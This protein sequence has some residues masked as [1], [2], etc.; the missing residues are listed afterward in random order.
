MQITLS[1]DWSKLFFDPLIKTK[2]LDYF[3]NE[4]MIIVVYGYPYYCNEKKW[5][6][7]NELSTKIL[8]EKNLFIHD[9]DGVFSIIYINKKRK[10]C[11]V[12]TDRY[13]IY[14]LYYMLNQEQI[15]LS[16]EIEA[17]IP[18]ISHFDINKK[19]VIEYLNFGYVLGDKTLI[20]G[21]RKFSGSSI[22]LI[23]KKLEI[24]REK[25]WDI[26]DIQKKEMMSKDEFRSEFNRHINKAFEL[27]QKIVLPL[28]GG[29]DSRLILSACLKSKEKLHCYTQGP[30]YHSDVKLAKTIAKYY[31][32]EH[33]H[34]MTGEENGK[35]L[36][37]K[38]KGKAGI[39]YGHLPFIEYLHVYELLE[40]EAGKGDLLLTGILGN[41]LYRHHPF[42]NNLPISNNKTDI[43][44]FIVYQTP[45]AFF[46][47]IRLIDFYNNLFT[48][49]N[50][51]SIEKGL[52][53]SVFEVLNKAEL[54]K[55]KLDFTRYYLFNIYCSNIAANSL[56]LTGRYFKIFGAFF[57]KT[58]LKQLKFADFKDMINAKL[59]EYIIG[60]NSKYLADLTYYN[61]GRIIKYL[62][63]FGN[64]ISTKIIHMQLFKHPDIANYHY[65]LK[66]N[67]S[68][69]LN[70]L[71]NYESMLSS[72][73]FNQVE[74]ERI[75]SI[76][77]GNRTCLINKKKLFLNF[78][79]DKFM[80]NLI[81]FELW[82]QE[83]SQGTPIR[84]L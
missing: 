3:E 41:Q 37:L 4:S 19:S 24:I 78:S 33:L 81:S 82:L 9:I 40:E 72:P 55:S 2:D 34:Y 15:T 54:A 56:K 51:D 50:A 43:A 44:R 77:I 49:Q 12:Y 83:T 73:L 67:N 58:L 70:E 26:L 64:K 38:V 6:L 68:Q 7:A 62:K 23:T 71:L 14:M 39:L 79:I 36:K 25:Y 31:G 35:D 20:H 75:I 76:Y 63:L 11:K 1:H 65:W 27:E 80:I 46:F 52:I 8:E 42:G 47:R 61:T 10:I 29:R 69:F 22:Y 53:D 16:D 28:T 13:G 57:N 21:V 84:F 60:N 18:Q 74:L 48:G 30:S 17:F 59:H 45:S 32:I 66:K 5:V